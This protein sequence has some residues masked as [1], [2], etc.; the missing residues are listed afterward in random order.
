MMGKARPRKDIDQIRL[1]FLASEILGSG[2]LGAFK[3][4]LSAFNS[5]KIFLNS[6]KIFVFLTVMRNHSAPGIRPA[7]LCIANN[8]RMARSRRLT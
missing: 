1:E 2:S 8:A 5:P 7:Q 6:P 3:S 4:M